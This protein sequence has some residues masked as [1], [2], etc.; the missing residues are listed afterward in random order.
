[1][2]CLG[3]KHFK[4]FY[5]NPLLAINVKTIV[6]VWNVGYLAIISTTCQIIL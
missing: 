5:H 1:M 2:S 6:K 3:F 4:D